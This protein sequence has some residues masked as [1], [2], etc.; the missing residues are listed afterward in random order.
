VVLNDYKCKIQQEMATKIWLQMA[1]FGGSNCYDI[2]HFCNSFF[3][4]VPALVIKSGTPAPLP[5]LE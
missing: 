5:F 4:R 1:V 2:N 3:G